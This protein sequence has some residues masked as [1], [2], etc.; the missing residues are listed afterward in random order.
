MVSDTH[1]DNRFRNNVLVTG[2]PLIRFYA[3]VALVT[4]AG[5]KIGTLCI[6][7]P[8]P[9]PGGLGLA[10]K[11]NLRELAEMVMD[12]LVNRKQ[13]MERLVDEK[14][15][16]IA[17][18]AHDLLSPLTGI[19]LNLGLLMEDETLGEKLDENQK[20]LMDAA[21]KCSDMLERICVEAIESFRG[22][23]KHVHEPIHSED[24]EN[25]GEK[26]LVN[27][28]LLVKYIEKVVGTIPK[29][30]P[31]FIQKDE[32]VPQ[33][34]ISDD[35]KLFR[36]VL[37]YLTN[38][39]KQTQS[40]SILLRIYVRTAAEY[41]NNM[42][43]GLLPGALFAPKRDSFIME[44]HD[45]GPG[46]PL[47]KYPSLFNPLTNK[48]DTNK[49]IA[50][51][52]HITNT[53]LG[54]YSVAT[55]IGS[56]GGEFGVF[57]KKDLEASLLDNDS[58]G[59]DASNADCESDISGS[60]FWLSVPL[61]LPAQA[62]QVTIW[63]QPKLCDTSSLMPPPDAVTLKRLYDTEER[64]SKGDPV[65]RVTKKPSIGKSWNSVDRDD[66][67]TSQMANE[68]LTND[69]EKNDETKRARCVLII[70][71]SL[72]IR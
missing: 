36:S 47:E 30:V 62:E 65:T 25:R 15:R 70:D 26:G 32:N 51:H 72:S 22:D 10:D 55:E 45:T 1:E 71:D 3:G 66:S 46:I 58:E 14:T 52:S 61:V 20:D 18:A 16:L 41:V 29:N 24:N 9:R 68:V 13:E 21:I 19:R 6:I 34:I 38:A 64:V 59:L 49:N 28:N 31:F 12:I 8:R 60:V 27:I 37:N 50:R 7:D 35:L 33:A 67:P 56:L 43:L 40:G 63:K 5:Y 54:L 39:C 4:P 53:G 2:N 23:L 44:V 42:E 17:C 57:P 69:E 48:R 11:Q